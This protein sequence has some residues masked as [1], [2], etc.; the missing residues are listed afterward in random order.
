MLCLVVQH[1]CVMLTMWQCKAQSAPQVSLSAHLLAHIDMQE[2]HHCCSIGI[3]LHC[4]QTC[5]PWYCPK[6]I[7]TLS[8]CDETLP[9]TDFQHEGVLDND[10]D[11]IAFV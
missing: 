4:Y 7:V 6:C 2:Y 10:A 9:C 3:M 5:P 1:S 8:E 11:P